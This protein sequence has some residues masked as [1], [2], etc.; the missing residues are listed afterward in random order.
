[1][2]FSI[3]ETAFSNKPVA[4]SLIF[5]LTI[6]VKKHRLFALQ[7]SEKKDHDF[8]TLQIIRI[9]PIREWPLVWQGRLRLAPTGHRSGVWLE[10]HLPGRERVPSAPCHDPAK[11]LL[12]TYDMFD[13]VGQSAA[14]HTDLFEPTWL[15]N[16]SSCLISRLIKQSKPMRYPDAGQV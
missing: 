12:L 1:M 3:R 2:R 8:G 13:R 5:I 9:L 4:D 10:R 16:P 11:A 15:T 6:E 14:L 7:M